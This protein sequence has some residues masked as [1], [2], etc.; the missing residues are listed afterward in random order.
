M[1]V[2]IAAQPNQV[3]NGFIDNLSIQAAEDDLPLPSSPWTKNGAKTTP[4]PFE[5]HIP[6]VPRGIVVNQ[7]GGGALA[8]SLNIN[9]VP[10]FLMLNY[11][12]NE[13]S[14]SYFI[15][16]MDWKTIEQ[17]LKGVNKQQSFEIK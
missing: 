5:S 17:N 3:A 9:K 11:E 6:H 4:S 7:L 13:M 2:M 14:R 12:G 8:Q 16:D 1:G 15:T 10:C